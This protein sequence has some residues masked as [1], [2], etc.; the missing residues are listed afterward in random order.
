MTCI[1][2]SCLI[3]LWGEAEMPL[4]KLYSVIR[5]RGLGE[6]I[7]YIITGDKHLVEARIFNEVIVHVQSRALSNEQI[8]DALLAGNIG[9]VSESPSKVNLLDIQPRTIAKTFH[10][11]AP[12][13]F[14]TDDATAQRL[15]SLLRLLKYLMESSAGG[16]A[17]FDTVTSEIQLA[18]PKFSL[19][20]ATVRKRID[21]FTN[22]FLIAYP[23][24][25]NETIPH[26]EHLIPGWIFNKITVPESLFRDIFIYFIFFG[27]VFEQV[28]RTIVKKEAGFGAKVGHARMSRVIYSVA[29]KSSAV[30][31][32]KGATQTGELKLICHTEKKTG[33]L[34]TQ[35]DLDKLGIR[36]GDTVSLIFKMK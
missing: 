35:T 10:A 14:N 23:F 26:D 32:Y 18:C 4:E 5:K 25:N 22:E 7:V 11:S 33:I 27:E 36:D 12:F 19:D 8:L 6:G 30:T 2:W 34:I 17:A 31:L 3:P 16:A 9:E 28:I 24:P 21:N 1:R 29:A 13:L 20:S 15:L